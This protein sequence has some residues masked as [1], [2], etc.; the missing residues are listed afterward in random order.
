LEGHEVKLALSLE[1][2]ER[3]AGNAA[4]GIERVGKVESFLS[5]KMLIS[6]PPTHVDTTAWPSEV[7]PKKLIKAE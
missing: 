4:I 2:S 1:R 3:Q 5:E 7:K 6:L